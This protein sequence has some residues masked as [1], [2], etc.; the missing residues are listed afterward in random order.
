MLTASLHLDHLDPSLPL[1]VRALTG[2]ERLGDPF[3]DEIST[4]SPR[5]S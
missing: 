4:S 3:R 1:S 5:S 2:T